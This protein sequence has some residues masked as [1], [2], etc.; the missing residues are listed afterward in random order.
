MALG[1]PVIATIGGGAS[2][3]ISSDSFGVLVP[4]D[5]PSALAREI[6][7][8]IDSP[9]KRQALGQAGRERVRSQFSIETMAAN[10]IGHLD[11][12][13]PTAAA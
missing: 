13:L 5:D 4:P 6:V 12:V 8:L 2:E 11:S 1:R 9:A 7:A 10:L 3:I